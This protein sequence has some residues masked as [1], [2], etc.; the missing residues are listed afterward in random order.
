VIRRRHTAAGLTLI[1][2]LIALAVLAI[3]LVAALRAG[4]SGADFGRELRLRQYAGY[5]ADNALIGARLM[6]QR[7]ADGSDRQPC[8]QAGFAF[9]CE[10]TVATAAHPG[11]REARVVVRLADEGNRLVVERVA[12]IPVA[13]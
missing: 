5:A 8:P 10:R 3:G 7:I 12:M 9:V 11:F 4:G 1:E 6:R 2:T 13:R